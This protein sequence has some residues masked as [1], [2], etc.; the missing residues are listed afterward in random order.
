MTEE[1]GKKV[2]EGTVADLMKDKTEKQTVITLTRKNA[3]RVKKIREQGTDDE[4][5]LFHFRKRCTG[6]GSYVHT[7]EAADGETELHPSEFEKW[8]AVEF[9]Y[10]GYLEDLL[11]AA[12]NAYRWSSFEPEARAETDIMQYEK[13][14][15]EDLKQIP[16]EKQNEYVSAYHSKF[17]ALLGSLSRCASPMVTGPAKFNCQRN[18]KALD[19]YQNRFDEFH[20]WRNRFKAAMERMKEAA[21]P[22]EQKQE[23]AWNRLKRDIASSAQ[24]IHDIDT[25]KAR[26]YS[27]ALFVSSILNKV[28][29]YAGKEKWKSYRKRWTSLQTSMRNA[30]TGYHSA[31]PFLPLPE[32]ARQARLK[33]QEIRER[34]NRELKFEGGTLVWNYEADRLQILFDSIPDD[35][36]RKELKSYGFKWSPRYQAWQRQLTQNAVYAVKRVLNLQNL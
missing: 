23:E 19:A 10:P 5:V 11:D 29:T 34:E 22:E 26:G 1:V 21:K 33:L 35:Q 32:M 15:V 7:I 25:G 4:A 30:K 14:L 12:Y 27:R 31:E 17:S 8:E 9:L 18:N 3:Y 36:R 20:D 6:M 16:E 28:S 24:T 13:Q 2:C